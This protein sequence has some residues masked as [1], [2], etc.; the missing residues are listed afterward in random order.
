MLVKTKAKALAD[1]EILQESIEFNESYSSRSSAGIALYL[2]FKIIYFLILLFLVKSETAKSKYGKTEVVVRNNP[3]FSADPKVISFKNY[4]LGQSYTQIISFRNISSV[5]RQLR[6]ISPK[7]SFFSLSPLKF[8]PSCN[9]GFIA[10][11]M[12]VTA[13]VTFTPKSLG[14]ASDY[15]SVQTEGGA[16]TVSIIASRE[17]PILNIPPAFRV[18]VC[19]VGDAVRVV[20]NIHNSGGAGSFQLLTQ[21]EFDGCDYFN[22]TDRSPA[23]ECLRA[24]PFAVYP[25]AFHLAAGQSVGLNVEFVPLQPMR[26][27]LDLVVVSDIKQV[28]KCTLEATGNYVVRLLVSIILVL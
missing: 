5:S 1:E 15:L 6:V 9:A 4:E 22:I 12:C 21:E 2:F 17:L 28:W 20:M 3:L 8:P 27:T 14:E 18:G 23:L 7:G 13:V 11:G 25:T 10:P 19:L 16:F 26:N 24:A